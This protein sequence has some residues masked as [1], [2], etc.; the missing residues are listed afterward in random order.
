MFESIDSLESISLLDYTNP[1]NYVY[2]GI[3]AAGVLL[4]IILIIMK[5]KGSFEKI[6]KVCSS[7]ANIMFKTIQKIVPSAKRGYRRMD[8]E[9]GY[10]RHN[11]LIDFSDQEDELLKKM[12]LP[13]KPLPKDY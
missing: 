4:L 1:D 12:R 3:A 10:N 9:Q 6:K 11:D 8:D 5:K 13:P 7:N 2:Y